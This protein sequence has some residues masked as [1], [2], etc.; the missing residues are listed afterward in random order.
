MQQGDEPNL[1]LALGALALA[2][3][4]FAASAA[5]HVFSN[6]TG[7]TISDNAAASLY[8]SGIT[9]SGLSGNMSKVE[10]SLHGLSH[11]FIGDLNILLVAPDGQT[12][13]LVRRP[14]TESSTF[15][16]G[17]DFSNAE[18]TFSASATGP[19]SLANPVPNGTYLPT[20]GGSTNAY[21]P[22]PVGP[23]S[24]DLTTL[25][26]VAQNGSWKLFIGDHAAGDTG[27]LSGGW[28]LNITTELSV[29]CASEGYTGT[30]L[31][32]C[33]NICEMGYTGST[34]NTLDP[35]LDGPL[36]PTAVLRHRPQPVPTEL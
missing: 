32:W 29:T 30:Q 19:V 23:Y 2:T 27:S 6:A 3:V 5:D 12:V 17:N 31:T 25:A 7:F 10:V 11:S 15:G 4:S 26:G 8:P 9:V 20:G 33:R 14:G 24:I 13:A 22:A 1:G 35:A 28:T 34:L 36:S 21:S 16:W 18:I